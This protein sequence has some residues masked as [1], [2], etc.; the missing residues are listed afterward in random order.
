MSPG[1]LACVIGDMDLVRPLALAGIRCAAA[2]T[3]G[4]ETR[5]SR[6]TTASVDLPDLWEE[7]EAAVDALVDFA[8][9]QTDKPVLFYQKDP[10]ALAISRH[11]DR[12]AHHFR[13]VVP[14][15]GLVEDLVDKE[16]FRRL[17]DDANLPVPATVVGTAG[18]DAAPLKEL[19]Y[20]VVLKPALR[21]QPNETW[22]PIAQGRK[23][24]RCDGPTELSELWSQP[25]LRGVTLLV[26][27]YIAG[28]EAQISSYHTYIDE[29][30]RTVAAFTGRKIRTWP[31][32][33][34]QSTAVE[35]TDDPD[36]VAAGRSVLQAIGF[37]GVAKVDLKADPSGRLHLL[38]INPRFSLWHHPGAVAGVNIPAVVYH[39]L[40]GDP[41][42]EAGRARAG[43]TWCQIWGDRRAAR[44]AGLGSLEW[45][46]FLAS[47]SARRAA[48]LGDPGSMAGALAYGLTGARSP[49]STPVARAHR[50]DQAK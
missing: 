27:Q 49:S 46:R 28:D 38:E 18:V 22:V 34:G 33:Y 8:R 1:P 13:F 37:T 26:Q 47:T 4:P 35:I 42:P 39:A 6:H 29:S 50:S 12:L 10:A 43:V 17:A 21:N 25:D 24:L 7:P 5:W 19:P 32:S 16:R 48:H 2:G 36:V 20:P 31:R 40:L 3:T 23:A 11:R 41:C 14:E 30:G 9:A 44:A 45:L 15:A